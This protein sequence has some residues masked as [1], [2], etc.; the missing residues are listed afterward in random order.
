[1]RTPMDGGSTH[2]DSGPPPATDA[3]VGPDGVRIV[4]SGNWN[5]VVFDRPRRIL[6]SAPVN[7]GD[8]EAVRIVNLCV[9]GPD[10][11]SY[12]DDPV[13][14]FRDLAAEQQWPG[15]TVGMMT[16]VSASR[17][18]VGRSGCG[19]ISWLVLAT[20][21]QS[22][23]HRAGEAP[24]PATGAGTINIIAVTSAALTAAARAEALMLV[25]EAKCA[26]LADAGI[27][28]VNG[29]GIATGTGTDAVSIAGGP[30]CTVQ[31]TG[32]HTPSGLALAR[33]TRSALAGSLAARGEGT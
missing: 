7:G 17:L 13:G 2:A 27:G 26:F 23:A 21:G 8:T 32:Y 19:G 28:S 22:N 4:R 11:M 33:A 6:S 25:T 12:C 3:P 24:V 16:G 29:C 15:T 20:L 10:V 1:M 31:Y 30:G 5:A 18:G 14:S 9:D